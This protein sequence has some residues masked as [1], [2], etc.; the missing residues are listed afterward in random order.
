VALRVL[1]DATGVPADR[2]AL[3]R[4]V[5]GLIGALGSTGIELA[6]ACQ[7]ADEERYRRHAPDAAIVP[8]PVGLGHRT[9]RLAWE[10]SGLPVVAQRVGADVLHMP[11]YSMPLRPGL[12]TVVTI[13]DITFFTDPERYSPTS[14]RSL[15]SA[16]MTAARQATRLIVPSNAT[17]DELVRMLEMDPAKIDVAY[18]GVDHNLF[19]R[20]SP[21]QVTHVTAR[22]GLRGKPYIAFLGSLT[23]RKNA[24][25]VV[26]GWSR[27]VADMENPPALVLGGGGGWSEDLD[28]AVAAVPPN[29]RLVRPG[30]LPFADLPGFLGGALVVAAPSRGEGFGLAVLEAMA[31]GAPVLTTNRTS[32]PEVGGGAVAYTEPDGD[33]IASALRALLDDAQRRTALGEAGYTRAKEFTWE[34]SAA[35]HAASYKRA[36]ESAVPG[37]AAG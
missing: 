30:Y 29:L 35:A 7:L 22:L 14:A 27:A 4:Y 16:T 31:C 17:R 11:Y 32:L 2:G 28:E 33:S 21:E 24:P 9:E 1:V 13:H 23:P 5:D 34:A 20:P 26:R 36:A 25:E 18:H 19:H 3:G 12:P 6:V 8:G 37:G 10:Q 15:K